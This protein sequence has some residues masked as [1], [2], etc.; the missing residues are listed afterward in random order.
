LA[1]SSL[2]LEKLPLGEH[3]AGGQIEYGEQCGVAMGDVIL[4]VPST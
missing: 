1:I 3:F 4:S 2:T